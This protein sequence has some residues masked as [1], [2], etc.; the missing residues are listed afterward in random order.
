MQR[1]RMSLPYFKTLD[2]E[3]EVVTVDQE[4]ADI[5][6]DKLLIESL[7]PAIKIHKVIAF[8]KKW[9]G[10]FGLGSI[11]LRSMYFYRKKVNSL[12]SK[13][14]YDLIYFSTTQFPICILGA[15]W[16]KKF[17]IPYIIDIQDMWHS[18]Y[19]QNKPKVERPKKYWFSYP[20]NKYLEPIAMKHVDG[21]ISVSKNYID[22]LNSRY[23]NLRSKPKEVI[24]FGA[25]DVDLKIAEKHANTLEIVY[26]TDLDRINLV[27][28]GR[29]GYDMR[30]SLQILF[31]CF[32]LGLKENQA[33]F[34][35]IHFNFIGTSYAP[36]GTGIPT[37]KPIANECG[38]SNYVTEF[39]DRIGFFQSIRNLQ[40][41]DGLII[42]GSNDGNYTASKLFPYILTQNHILAILHADSSARTILNTCNAGE[43]I[44]LQEKIT[45][46]S[47]VFEKFIEKISNNHPVNINWKEFEPYTAA[48]LTKKQTD[49]FDKI[50]AH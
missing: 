25:F 34:K 26:K 37:I 43:L 27:Y 40:K 17:G 4:Y 45:N 22:I 19:Y 20:L 46:S 33:L 47:I 29:G 30:E 23:S 2:W 16:K 9:T 11:A 10:K 24:T 28:I 6:T 38:V 31:E 1:V 7:P 49:F 5:A 13:N 18:D 36:N 14:K 50:I 32:K 12:L 44:T 8:K 3:A 21:I 15:Y 39:T 35:R 41:A 42:I 48:Y